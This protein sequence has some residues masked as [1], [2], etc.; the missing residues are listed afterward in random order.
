MTSASLVDSLSPSSSLS[1]VSSFDPSWKKKSIIYL[2][3]TQV[4]EEANTIVQI[5]QLYD[6]MY[7]FPQ[8]FFIPSPNLMI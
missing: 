5:S 4:W 8:Q 3:R 7:F 6:K 1:E 2:L